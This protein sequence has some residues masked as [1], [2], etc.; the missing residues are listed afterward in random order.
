MSLIVN[1]ENLSKSFRHKSKTVTALSGVSFQLNKGELATIRGKSGC[2]K[3]TLLLT[4]G[5]LQKPDTGTVSV[6]GQNIYELTKERRAAVRAGQIGFVFQQFHLIPYLS[7]MENVLA[8]RLGVRAQSNGSPVHRA[9]EL[10]DRLGLDERRDHRP[11]ELSIGECQRVAL[12]RALLNRP[13][14][15]LA[16]E[17]TGN[18]DDENTETVLQ[19]LRAIADDGA[20]VLLVTHDRQCDRAANHV[21]HMCDGK[22]VS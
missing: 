1:C 18:L 11:A 16:D 3:S 9:A 22:L 19:H 6:A 15:I 21:L 12:A 8:A 10:V 2:G 14:L 7:V 4:V 5:A 20:A 13:Q 17:P